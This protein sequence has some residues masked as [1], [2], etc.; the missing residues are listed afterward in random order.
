MAV[1]TETEWEKWHM[2]AAG[3]NWRTRFEGHASDGGHF[4]IVPPD[5]AR[6]TVFLDEDGARELRDGLNEYLGE[7]PNGRA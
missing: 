6:S 1:K 7:A 4:G 2:D 3:Q 5:S